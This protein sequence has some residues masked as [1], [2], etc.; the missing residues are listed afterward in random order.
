MSASHEQSTRDAFESSSYLSA[1]SAAYVEGLYEAYLENPA[2]VSDH[3][4]DYFASF[5][6]GD[7]S[8]ADILDAL[9]TVANQPKVAA[10]SAMMMSP[11]KQS[12]V[13]G[14]IAAYRRY[15]HLNA[16]IDPL[17]APVAPDVRLQLSHHGL[18]AA[19][20]TETFD[21]RKLF[22][23]NGTA[24]L[25]K[26]QSTLQQLYCGSMGIEYTRII[27]ETE[28]EWLRD[29]VEIKIPAMQFSVDDK[30][31]ILEKLTQA[32]GLEK[33]LD[34]K[35]PGQKRFSIEGADAL[36]PMMDFLV[37][38]ARAKNLHECVI[39]MAHR[40]RLNVLLNIMGKA[41]AAL[42]DEF[43]G[44][45][46]YGDTSGD[47]KY[48]NGFSSDVETAHGAIHLS[49]G[50]NPSHLEF[51][52]T[53]VMGST[54]ARQERSKIVDKKDYA[55][56]VL[57]HGDAAF[58]GQ[59]IVM[60]TLAMS[61]TRAYNVGGTVHI[62]IN[63]Q[64]GFTTSNPAD[65]RSSHYCSDLAKMIDAPILH[66]NG[67]DAEACVRA[68]KLALDYRVQFH[69]DVVIDLVCYRVHGHN[70][71]DEPMCTQPLMYQIIRA[72][73]TPR[74]LYALQLIN[75]KSITAQDAEQMVSH[76]R[77]QL[78]AGKPVIKL[79]QNGLS[80]HYT[81]NWAP[82]LNHDWKAKADTRVAPD[83]LKMLG[84]KI[85]TI[86]EGFSLQRQ[87]AM[88]MQAR[89]KMVAGE[90][91]LDWGCAET[92]AYAALLYEG[93]PVRFTGEDVRRGTFF[94]RHAA[95]LDQKSGECYMPLLHISDN[96]AHCQMYDSLLSETGAL[97]FEYGY[98]AADPSSLTMWEAQFGDFANVA[99][100][101]ID[102]FISS[103]WQKWNR[104]SGLV[105]LLPH[106]SEGQGPEHSSARLERYLQLCAQE[107]MQVCVPSTPAQIFHLLR[108]QVIRAY[109]K[110]LIVM[111][112]KS[113]LRH[114]LAV[115]H[116]DE[117]T[118]GEFHCVIPEI[119]A[120]DA[121]KVDRLV[122][123]SGKI[124]YELLT[125]RREEKV[126][127]VAIARIEQ[128]YP[129][130]DDALKA[131]MNRYPNLK[132]IVWCQEEPKNQGAFYSSRH[133]IVRCMP[134]GTHLFYA[135]RKAMAA[136]AAGYA[137]LFNKQQ[138]DLIDQALGFTPA[139]ESK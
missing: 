104:L 60:E 77:D 85:T 51:I 73:K 101:I 72:K 29:Y 56:P 66:V 7:I 116:W 40:G 109:R 54:R 128:L 132:E 65:T 76:Y 121:K 25:E 19:D 82:F 94:H 114:K 43:E 12:A 136:P 97:G 23:H 9:R 28:R 64:V 57:I 35:Y 71:A 63:N 84:M 122:L 17:D 42:F 93:H 108:R 135:G 98:S 1:E 8:H 46:D 58:A 133:R 118:Q 74:A 3:W 53:V 124:Y 11:Q 22:K 106:G 27:N 39:G 70:E 100:V 129:F 95:L 6:G 79:L 13:D 18:S 4:R 83:V 127:H 103:A 21:A 61:Q 5:G 138:A 38:D 105:M 91:P 119:D 75:E 86:P 24:T 30:K 117:L 88:I 87:V 47:V 113:L 130:P 14:L 34:T 134:E 131:E 2:N 59:G 81:A 126:D 44:K 36:I 110:P 55:F 10:Q 137:A 37:S 26:I 20:L 52:N 50:F 48:H 41:P 33:Y 107:N 111:S 120:L 123:C 115:S 68:I 80:D 99:Q 45:K 89:I 49:L 32:E 67:E 15:G 92:L 69:K 31:R 112:P 78:D 96:Q 16:K 62:I 90:Q 139:D 102:Q 125:K